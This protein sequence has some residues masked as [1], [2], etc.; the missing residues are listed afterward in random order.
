MLLCLT[1]PRTGD[2]AKFYWL[3]GQPGAFGQVPLPDNG[4]NGDTDNGD[5]VRKLNT[6]CDLSE[7]GVQRRSPS[8]ERTGCRG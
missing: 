6:D 1:L 3:G 2:F 4:D 8:G 7:N 5:T